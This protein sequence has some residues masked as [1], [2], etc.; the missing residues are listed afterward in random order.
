MNLTISFLTAQQ[1]QGFKNAIAAADRALI[2][3]TPEVSAIR[4]AD[5]II[6]LLEANDIHKIDLVINRI[7]MDMVERGDMLSKDDVLDILAVDLIGI[8]SFPQT[9]ENHWLEAI[10]QQE[11]HTRISV[12]V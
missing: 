10:H 7:R 6:G 8:L 3:T 9:R 1:E 2:V 4:D 12:I 11:K 5:R